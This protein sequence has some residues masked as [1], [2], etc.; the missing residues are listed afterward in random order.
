MSIAVFIGY[1]ERLVEVHRRFPAMLFKRNGNHR[2]NN[3]REAG[4]IFPLERVNQPLRFDDLKVFTA[5]PEIECLQLTVAGIESIRMQAKPPLPSRP[6]IVFNMS[7]LELTRSG[8]MLHMFRVRPHLPHQLAWRIEHPRNMQLMLRSHL[9]RHRC[10]THRIPPFVFAEK[11]ADTCSASRSSVC[12]PP[13]IEPYTRTFSSLA[14][15]DAK[16]IRIVSRVLS[17]S[18]SNVAVIS[19]CAA[20]PPRLPLLSLYRSRSCGTTSVNMLLFG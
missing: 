7:R 20:G 16:T 1:E 8:P 11:R 9:R 3:L 15:A 17:P 19:N 18:S 13:S 14:S 6:R 10:C 4:V 12:F 2:L 5:L